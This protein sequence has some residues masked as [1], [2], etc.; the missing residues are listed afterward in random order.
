MNTKNITNY[1]PKDFVEWL[2]AQLRH[3][4]VGEE[5]EIAKELQDGNKSDTGAKT[6]D[7]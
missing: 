7:K 4:N 2:G 6:K 1:K 3:C 5:E